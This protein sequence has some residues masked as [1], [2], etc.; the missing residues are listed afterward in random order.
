MDREG[1]YSIFKWSVMFQFE[2]NALSWPL[3]QSISF[4]RNDCTVLDLAM[5]F[6]IPYHIW[7]PCHHHRPFH[8]ADFKHFISQL[9]HRVLLSTLKG[10]ERKWLIALIIRDISHFRPCIKGAIIPPPQKST[11]RWKQII[12]MPSAGL[13]CLL[14]ISIGFSLVQ[15]RH[16]LVETEDKPQGKTGH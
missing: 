2:K 16:F 14:T 12:T 10:E 15:G 1:F 8:L 4:K 3:R 6:W 7:T 11:E 9:L 5:A 13:L